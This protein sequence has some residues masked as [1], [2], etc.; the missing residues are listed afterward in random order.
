M[1]NIKSFTQFNESIDAKKKAYS[2]KATVTACAD[3]VEEAEDKVSTLEFEGVD[4]GF[5]DLQ[6][7]TD[8][9]Y[10]FKTELTINSTS[11][12]DAENALVALNNKED[13]ANN[14]LGIDIIEFLFDNEHLVEEE[15]DEVLEE[16]FFS[17]HDTLD[18]LKKN[19]NLYVSQAKRDPNYKD[20]KAE[21]FAKAKDLC[22]STKCK[23]SQ[24][25]SDSV[26]KAYEYLVKR[27]SPVDKKFVKQGSK[28]G[29]SF[30]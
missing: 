4:V 25:E 24:F 22:I 2:F 15:A 1:K 11:K 20:I 5:L 29:L 10:A 14:G 28:T 27:S 9:C 16:G 19:Y 8:G 21:D 12:Q 26:K 3:S 7:E 13:V 30:T 17:G 6:D 18:D 23:A